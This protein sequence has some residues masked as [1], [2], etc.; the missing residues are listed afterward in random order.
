MAALAPGSLA[1]APFDTNIFAAETYQ[2][3]VSV[4]M[5]SLN[6]R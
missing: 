6:A 1:G 2:L 3:S 5:R 4:G